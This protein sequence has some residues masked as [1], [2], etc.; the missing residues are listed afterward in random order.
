MLRPQVVMHGTESVVRDWSPSET[1]LLAI[2]GE[3]VVRTEV[4]DVLGQT[5]VGPEVDLGERSALEPSVIL[6]SLANSRNPRHFD[7]IEG[8]RVYQVLHIDSKSVLDVYVESK[9]V[10]D[11]LCRVKKCLRHSI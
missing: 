6:D 8:G 7:T 10:L 4:R 3:A 11:A 2:A 5:V 9:S 1:V